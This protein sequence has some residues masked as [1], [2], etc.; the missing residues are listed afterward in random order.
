MDFLGAF[1]KY[2]R[3]DKCQMK[4]FSFY[5][6]A[7]GTVPFCFCGQSR[8]G[9]DCWVAASLPSIGPFVLSEKFVCDMGQWPHFS[10]IVLILRQGLLTVTFSFFFF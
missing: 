7:L 3:K 2:S 6:F 1:S 5:S 10:N 8:W 9:V 4:N